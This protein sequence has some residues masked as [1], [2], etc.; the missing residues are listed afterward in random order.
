[1]K[2]KINSIYQ[3]IAC[4]IFTICLYHVLTN[5]SASMWFENSVL[6]MFSILVIAL[7]L[8]IINLVK[9]QK[10]V[11]F[12]LI[13]TVAIMICLFTYLNTVDG[14]GLGWQ[15]YFCGLHVSYT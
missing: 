13:I 6:I 15:V 4:I 5:T 14:I 9:R 3:A 10:K 7:V 2:S 1:M 8:H 11:V 12:S